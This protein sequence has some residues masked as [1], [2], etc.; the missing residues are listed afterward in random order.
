MDAT[1]W[2]LN[3]NLLDGTLAAFKFTRGD[4]ETVIKGADGNE[5]LS[6]LTFTTTYGTTGLQTVEYTVLNWRDPI[7]TS[8]SPLDG[9][10]DVDQASLVLVRF[11]QAMNPAGTFAVKLGA[12]AVPGTFSYDAATNTFTFTPAEPLWRTSTYT[13]TVSG[14][15]DFGG[16][17]QQNPV[18]FSFSTTPLR[19]Y[20]PIISNN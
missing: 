12:D 1:H 2:T 15:V 14:M 3:F 4:W 8:H 5:E 10:L 6:D 17:V 20:L 19:Y 11:S 13:V 7:V 16:D 18:T 9:A